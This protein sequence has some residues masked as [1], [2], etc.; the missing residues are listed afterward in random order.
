M[1]KEQQI[2]EQIK[3]FFNEQFS[4]GDSINIDGILFLI[5]VQELG[6]GNLKFSKD[7]KINL[8]HIA[9]CK[10]LEPFGFY[11][12]EKFDKEGW[13][14]YINISKLP[15]LLPNE[16]ILLIKKAIIYYFKNENLLSIKN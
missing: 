9:I 6:K 13:P 11:K 16:Q 3:L 2:W 5:G 4:E 1:K 7:D 15:N 8:I 10:L 12:F 14:Y